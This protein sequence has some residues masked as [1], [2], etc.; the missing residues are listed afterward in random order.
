MKFNILN[1]LIYL[2]TSITLFGNL[3]MALI[4]PPALFIFFVFV[5]RDLLV[6]VMF[7]LFALKAD[8]KN[9]VS[10][11]VIWLI[12]AI[13]FSLA[14]LLT[15]EIQ[16]GSFVEKFR[17][18]F[19]IPAFCFVVMQNKSFGTVSTNLLVLFGIFCL[20]EAAFIMTLNS[21]IFLEITN[22]KS[23]LSSKNT[24]VGYGFGLF[25]QHRLLT[26]M[27]QPSLGGIF[28]SAIII[29]LYRNKRWIFATVFIIPL[30][31]TVSKTGIILL[32]LWPIIN[33]APIASVLALSLTPI[34]ALQFL[35]TIDNIHVSSIVYHFKGYFEGFEHL[36]DPQGVGNTGTV[37]SLAGREVGA[38]SGLGAF[39][40]GFGAFGLIPLLIMFTKRLDTFA[41]L[42]LISFMFTEISMNLYIAAI[43]LT[44]ITTVNSHE[45]VSQ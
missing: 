17:N 35:Y 22:F 9:Q 21:A 13:L 12:C 30:I 5:F 24:E 41:Y 31:M 10:L 29:F 40:A 18:M 36:L 1:I 20:V 37:G 32:I 23:Y 6:V 4:G 3:L 19:A 38:E 14:F 7:I 11:A 43:F 15:G 26:P 2:I 33:F 44:L 45:K 42:F 34:L 28:L 25:G 27:F 16:I 8:F 39:L